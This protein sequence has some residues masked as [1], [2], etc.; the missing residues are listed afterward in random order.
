MTTD[1]SRETR[2]YAV[3]FVAVL[4]LAYT[5][6]YI[7]RTIL[8][9]MVAPIRASLKISDVQLSL[10]HGFAFAIFYTFMGIPIG[11]LVDRYR[12]TII[13]AIGIAIWSVATALC[14]FATTFTA[15]FVARIA[16]GVGESTLSPAAYSMLADKFSGKKL[17]RALAF[18]QSAI[19]L[20]PAIAT[21]FGGV[22]LAKLAPV[23]GAFGHFEPWQ[24][25]FLIV[26]LPGLLIALL[27]ATLREPA[28]RGAGANVT[29]PSLGAVLAHMRA[30]LGAY[31]LLILGLCLQS[32]MWNGAAA[33]FPTH[34]IRAYGYTTSDVAWSYGPIIA[35]CGTAGGLTGGWLAGWL[36]DRERSD[37]NVLIG[38]IA[39]AGACPFAF[40][41]PL[42]PT[43]GASLTLIGI[44]LFMGAMPYG[45]AAA[46]FQEI[47]PNRMRGQVSAVYLFWLNLAGIGLGSTLVALATEHLYG[48][49]KGVSA[50]LSTVSGCA[51]LA[52]V[53]ALLACLAPYRRAMASGATE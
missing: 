42:M 44:F 39:A 33:W 46:A 48:G 22:I 4:I 18:Y 35:I 31:G 36:R 41:A 14:G 47:T 20:G 24:I 16:V 50:A 29:V 8:T 43:A 25:V 5:F 15:M 7:D 10:L 34:L 38:V 2:R 3:W 30:A 19:Y 45:G 23:D 1:E 26:G 53:V 32:I 49:D 12:R 11:R 6:S 40:A 28:R 13:V 9:L 52:S 51:A 21:V 27:F 17:V 37:S